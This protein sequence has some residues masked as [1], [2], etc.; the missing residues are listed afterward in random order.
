MQV[1]T[2]DAKLNYASKD[3]LYTIILCKYNFF[4]HTIICIIQVDTYYT[5]TVIY[6][7]CQYIIE[8]YSAYHMDYSG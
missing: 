1:E 7:L 3:I 2:N 8:I 5:Y 6:I 4:M